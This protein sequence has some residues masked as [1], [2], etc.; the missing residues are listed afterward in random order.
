[1]AELTACPSVAREVF[2]NTLMAE[3]LL[4]ACMAP[5]VASLECEYCLLKAA[6]YFMVD[7]VE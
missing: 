5:V 3:I 2:I 7:F 4:S 6:V 1:V